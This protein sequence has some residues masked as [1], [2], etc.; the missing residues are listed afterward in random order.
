MGMG[1]T[2]RMF[3]F[4]HAGVD[5]DLVCVGKALSGGYLPISATIAKDRIYASFEG[6]HV[7][8]HGH[9]F[10]GNPIAAAAARACLDIYRADG[11]VDR[12][13]RLGEFLQARLNPLRS[14]PA[15]KEVRCLGLIGAVELH[16]V[17]GRPRR[18]REILQQAGVLLRPL[19]DVLYIMPPLTIADDELSQLIDALAIAIDTATK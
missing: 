13:A 11:I 15:V 18:V 12:A 10:C 5:P 4:E 7:L 14:H 6:H 17:D 16:P 1:R 3:A 2:G 9:T 19:G 8:Q